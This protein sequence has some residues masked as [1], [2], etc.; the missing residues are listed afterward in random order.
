M[1]TRNTTR[2]PMRE[3]ILDAADNLLARYGYQKTTDDDL[4]R[5][6]G[7]GRRTIYIHFTNKE[8]IF[9]ASIDRVI[10]R[11]LSEL[12]RLATT[13]DTPDKKLTHILVARV[14]FRMDSVHNYHLSLDDMFAVLRP[15][16]LERRERYFT[17]EAHVLAEV[18]TEGQ[19]IG[20][21]TPSPALDTARTL[22]LATNSLLPYS[23][24]GRELG[25]REDIERKARAIAQLVLRGLLRHDT[26]HTA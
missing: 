10:E 16:Y 7:I 18:I 15:A 21:F 14:L 11:L 8:E 12:R 22:L 20:I 23:L 6:A 13:S 1:I 4:A 9:L 24:S 2:S 25:S 26:K 17:N 19:R 5:E 3:R